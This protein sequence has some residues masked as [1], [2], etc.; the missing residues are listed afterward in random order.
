MY[1]KGILALGFAY[2]QENRNE[3]LVPLDYHSRPASNRRIHLLQE[4]AP[5]GSL[6]TV[7]FSREIGAGGVAFSAANKD[8]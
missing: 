2:G 3:R 6:L 7:A 4:V 5:P 1:R 8:F